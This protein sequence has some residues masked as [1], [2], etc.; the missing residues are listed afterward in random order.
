MGQKLLMVSFREKPKVQVLLADI[1]DFLEEI[2]K[3]GVSPDEDI[4][5]ARLE[6]IKT[7]PLVIDVLSAL[8]GAAI[9][10]TNDILEVL[11]VL[12]YFRSTFKDEPRMPHA[13]SRALTLAFNSKPQIRNGIEKLFSETYFNKQITVEESIHQISSLVTDSKVSDLVCIEEIMPRCATD[14]ENVERAN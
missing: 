6:F 4:T 8:V 10:S 7:I 5:K 11:R 13:I 1:A 2:A 14:K 9:E 3:N 12:T